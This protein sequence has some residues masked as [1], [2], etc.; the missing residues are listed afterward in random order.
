MGKNEGKQMS[1]NNNVI[2]LKS[3]MKKKIEALASYYPLHSPQS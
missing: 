1:K 2:H 3:R